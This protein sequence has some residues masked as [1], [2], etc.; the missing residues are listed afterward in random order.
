[1]LRWLHQVKEIEGL[2]ETVGWANRRLRST[3]AKET[4]SKKGLIEL[5]WAQLL[6]LPPCTKQGLAT[7]IQFG[8][9]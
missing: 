1:M 6:T 9:M 7:L 8:L 4:P 3:A 2:L 5:I